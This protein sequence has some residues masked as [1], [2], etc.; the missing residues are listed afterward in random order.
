M[1]CSQCGNQLEEGSKFCNVCGAPVFEE[2][3]SL[4]APTT[5]KRTPKTLF[6]ILAGGVLVILIAVFI[7]VKPFGLFSKEDADSGPSEG[8]NSAIIEE[9]RE[10]AYSNYLNILD[11][12]E[13]QIEEYWC[14]NPEYVEL[15]SCALADVTGDGVDELFIVRQETNVFGG[16]LEVYSYD[17]SIGSSEVILNTGV[18]QGGMGNDLFVFLS[19]DEDVIVATFTALDGGYYGDYSVWSYDGEMYVNTLEISRW[20]EFSYDSVNEEW[21]EVGPFFTVNGADA[22]E[23]DYQSNESEILTNPCVLLQT[24]DG[25][26]EGWWLDNNQLH[27][28]AS[29]MDSIAVTYDDMFEFL[30]SFVDGP[31]S[32]PVMMFDTRGGTL[33]AITDV[34]GGHFWDAAR[35][36][37]VL[38]GY[39]VYIFTFDDFYGIHTNQIYDNYQTYDALES[40]VSELVDYGCS[41]IVISVDD[42][43][44]NYGNYRELLVEEFPNVR[45]DF[46]IVDDADLAFYH[47]Y[48]YDFFNPDLSS[49]NGIYNFI[50][51]GLFAFD[52]GAWSICD[53]L[54]STFQ[55]GMCNS[56]I[57][58]MGSCF[59]YYNFNPLDVLGVDCYEMRVHYDPD[60]DK[61]YEVSFYVNGPDNRLDISATEA[62]NAYNTLRS[63]LIS[64]WGYYNE[65]GNASDYYKTPMGDIHLEWG[66]YMYGNNNYYDCIITISVPDTMRPEY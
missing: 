63:N 12:S 14:Y 57:D 3:V 58:S 64:S 59:Y 34:G 16:C 56:Y 19:E 1:F 50:T 43:I 51:T 60:Y 49:T 15:R 38:D 22:T 61:I 27:Q 26:W 25:C 45:F 4:E 17:P 44:G 11:E 8:D 37:M 54:M 2:G 10:D 29:T 31:D 36:G 24:V 9:Y 21:T 40:A 13:D 52:D 41:E 35:W 39:G 48:S 65:Q 30:S 66:N 6:L 53:G 62:E 5:K 20:E 32:G 18:Y 23:A 7:I 33:G 47:D 55:G 28:V 42:N 46:D